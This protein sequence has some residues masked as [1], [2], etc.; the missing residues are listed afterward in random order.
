MRI[1]FIITFFLCFISCTSIHEDRMKGLLPEQYEVSLVSDTNYGIPSKVKIYQIS[2]EIQ[3]NNL[4]NYPKGNYGDRWLFK[5]WHIV[6]DAKE[7]KN[8]ISMLEMS[9]YPLT[10]NNQSNTYTVLTDSIASSLRTETGFVT[11]ECSPPKD[12]KLNIYQYGYIE[13][14]Y[15]M[16]KV[17]K[18][19]YISFGDI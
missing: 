18:L 2:T 12:K 11:Y 19:V 5:P 6:T 3:Y 4:M 9:K 7:K 14:Y 16:P 13:F 8:L 1:T 15:I 10:V 17:N